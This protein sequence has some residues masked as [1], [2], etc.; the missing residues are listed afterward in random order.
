MGIFEK[1]GTKIQYEISKLL[2]DPKAEEYN[3]QQEAQERQDA[4]TRR[5]LEEETARQETEAERRATREKEAE[6]LARRSEFSGSRAIGDIASGTLEAIQVLFLIILVLYGGSIAVN[7]AIG[8]NTPFRIIS[9][10]YGCLFFF[11]VIPKHLY[12]TYYLRNP[13]I[14]YSM[15][16]FVVYNPVGYTRLLFGPFCYMENSN[17]QAATRAVEMLY[18]QGAGIQVAASAIA[19]GSAAAAAAA[20]AAAPRPGARPGARPV[21][22]FMAGQP[23]VLPVVPGMTGPP[24]AL[25]IQQP[26]PPAQNPLVPQ[27]G[28]TEVFRLTPKE[29]K[30]YA[31]A[32]ATRKASIP[33]EPYIKYFSNTTPK[34]IG[35]CI[36]Y[37]QEGYGDGASAYALF[38]AYTDQSGNPI[39]LDF[40]VNTCFVERPECR[41]ADAT[42][43]TGTGV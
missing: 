6:D 32:E 12:S 14:Y 28:E 42:P 3:K 17:S 9:L 23:G 4:M 5:R 29:G 39:R 35:K 16:P 34:Y 27:L 18:R 36:S 33:N 37:H 41:P 43:P 38:D 24:G 1:L 25:P 13:Y 21:T 26:Y 30:C 20:G 15:F 7:S 19:V 10:I 31:Y 40:T 8:Y 22:P 2:N 11:L